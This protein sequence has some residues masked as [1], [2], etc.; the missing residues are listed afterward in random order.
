MIIESIALKN[1]QSY[2]GELNENTFKFTSGINIVTGE[3]GAGKS[4]LFDAFYWIL[5]DKIFS[6]DKREF[7][8]TAEYKDKIISD[9][10]KENCQIEDTITSEVELTVVDSEDRLYRLNRSF[11]CTR[12]SKLEFSSPGISKLVIDEY[13]ITQWQRVGPERIESLLNRIIPPHLKPYMWFQGEQVDSLM[14]FRN[15]EAL[16]SVIDLL[17]DISEYDEFIEIAEKGLSNS[18]KEYQKA[19]KK[20]NIEGSK[21]IQLS[22]QATKDEDEIRISEKKLEEYENEYAEA[23]IA[24]DTLASKVKAAEEYTVLKQ[25]ID[26][27]DK[28]IERLRTQEESLI[29]GLNKKLF[30]D[31]WVLYALESQLEE[32]SRKYAEYQE[33]HNAKVTIAT[34]KKMDL[35]IDIPQPIY[36]SKMLDEQR[37]FV[38]GREALEGSEPHNHIKNLLERRDIVKEGIFKTDCSKYFEGM[39]NNILRNSKSVENIKD[40]I[41]KEYEK[42]N[43]ISAMISSEKEALESLSSKLVGLVADGGAETTV[44]AYRTHSRKLAES[45]RR[46]QEER[47]NLEKYRSSLNSIKINLSKLTTGNIDPSISLRSEIFEKIY[48]LS[49]ETRENVFDKLISEL[50]SKANEIFREMTDK[51]NSI[52]G[53]LKI[54]K[55]S[56]GKCVS[57]IVD[58]AGQVMENTNDSNLVITRL[59]LIMAILTLRA[60]WS[61]NYCLIT[62]AP[63]SKMA[64]NYSEGF[65]NALGSN[66]S[67]SIVMTYDF[68]D[69]DDIDHFYD[70]KINRVYKITPFY[71]NGDRED[72]K[73]LSV[74]LKRIL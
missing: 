22:D 47:T 49:R 24:I 73:D 54:R 69:V 4:K 74:N 64:K 29:K 13:K 11:I 55:T 3:N 21:A 1:F 44:S 71:P 33:E 19:V 17:S 41:A 63:T 7:I 35:P 5:N 72:R 12:I 23:E 70:M 53:Y 66:F 50:E 48:T 56:K 26:T 42:I 32:Y 60:K 16:S 67:Q 37:C 31:N 40:H 2:F 25:K 65:Y 14:D 30:T 10:A 51:N 62:D 20:E 9:K 43:T 8:S 52:T 34:S 58:S 57:E 36:V 28:E 68:A 27:R 46:V 59:S 45:S 39:Y 18:K 6:S 38:C 15:S 61:K